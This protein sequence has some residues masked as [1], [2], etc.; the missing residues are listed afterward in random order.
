MSETLDIEGMAAATAAIP[1]T[2]LQY[3]ADGWCILGRDPETGLEVHAL[4]E[5]DKFHVREVMPVDELV[6]ENAEIRA[7]LA[8]RRHGDGLSL[9]A[10]VPLNVFWNRLAEPLRQGDSA[11]LRRWLNDSSHAAFR[12]RG[13]V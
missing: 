2:P 1:D 9:A 3:T 4:D 11:H 10:R 8:G 7:A 12:V 5:G 6:A 13:K